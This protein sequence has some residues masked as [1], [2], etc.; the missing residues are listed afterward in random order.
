[1]E[2]NNMNGTVVV[3]I[4]EKTYWYNFKE[5]KL[6]LKSVH[7]EFIETAPREAM[8]LIMEVNSKM[9]EGEELIEMSSHNARM[10]YCYA[11]L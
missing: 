9:T 1:M 11:T 2:K 5:D 7:T 8:D 4:I 3:K 6:E 10:M